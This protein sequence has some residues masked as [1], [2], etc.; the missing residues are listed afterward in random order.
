[1]A[2]YATSIRTRRTTTIDSVIDQIGVGRFQWRLLFVNGLTWAADAM[3][4]LIAGFVLPGVAAHFGF[5]RTGSQA[6]LFLSAAFAGMFLGALVWGQLADRFGRRNVFLLTVLLDA[7]FGLASALAPSFGL[8][9]AFRFLT[10]FAVGGTLPVDYSLLAEY[11]PTKQRGKFLVYLESFWALG[12]IIV[13][14]LAWFV[15]SRFVP[16]EAWRWVLGASAIPGL[17]GYW[18]RRGVPE[19]PRYLLIQGKTEEARDVLHSIARE[20]GQSVEVGDLEA[21]RGAAGVPF[22][23]IWRGTLARRTILLSIAWFCLSLGYYGIFSWLPIFFRTQGVDLGNV[24][25]NTLILALA[26]V[27][28]YMLAAYLV[29]RAGR[30]ATLALFLFASAL[31][32][33]LFALAT[34]GSSILLTSSLLSFSLLGA[35]GALYTYSPEL[36]PTDARTTGMGWVSAMARLA[37]IFAPTVG[38]LL[39]TRSLPLALGVYA[40]FFAV[41]GIAA[42]LMGV[43]TRNQRLVDVLSEVE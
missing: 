14:A 12:T 39:L 13:A 19:S 31:A 26:Q 2:T 4:V 17:I 43:E 34:G 40:A 1:M 3:E 24:Y 29:D 23:A 27:P 22:A 6:T 7:I 36:F 11:V 32:S 30:R 16:E 18:I 8:L 37:S 35:W 42:L 5:E 25:R 28:G 38:G 33:F 9:L 15:F 41:G 20:N 21:P 10:G